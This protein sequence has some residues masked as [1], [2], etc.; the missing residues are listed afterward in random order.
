MPLIAGIDHHQVEFV[1]GTFGDIPVCISSDEARILRYLEPL[2]TDGKV[3]LVGCCW[4]PDPQKWRDQRIML[5]RKD[6]A[7]GILKFKPLDQSA[8]T[9]SSLYE[10]VL[11]D[12]CHRTEGRET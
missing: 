3:E 5:P 2:E 6:E 9:F 10:Y 4:D 8:S 11:R 7:Q 1:R 12:T